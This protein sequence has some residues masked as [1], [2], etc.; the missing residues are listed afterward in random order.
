VQGHDQ[1]V[2]QQPYAGSASKNGFQGTDFNV[3]LF[4]LSFSGNFSLVLSWHM[5]TFCSIAP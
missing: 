1:E 2:P 4:L 3:V 5:P